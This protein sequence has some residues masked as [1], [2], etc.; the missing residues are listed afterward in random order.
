MKHSIKKEITVIF[1]LLIIGIIVIC[2]LMNTVFLEKFY[3]SDKQQTLLTVYDWI[4]KKVQN[5]DITSS[6]FVNKFNETC[7]SKNISV[8]VTTPNWEEVLSSSGHDMV[9]RMQMIIFGL[10][11][12]KGDELVLGSGINVRGK[13]P[14][15]THTEKIKIC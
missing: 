8:L 2:M 15:V 5:D 1:L 7:D 10:D 13:G 11:P 14:I 3:M 6:D 12:D 4:D 9:R